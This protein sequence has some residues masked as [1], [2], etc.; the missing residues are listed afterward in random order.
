M[1][2]CRAAHPAAALLGLVLSGCIGDKS[3]DVQPPYGIQDT[4]D[5]NDSN[6]RDRDGDG[7][8][9]GDGDCNDEDPAVHPGAAD[10]AGD[11]LDTDCDGA[12]G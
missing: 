11:G 12:D 5:I 6:A 2:D 4:R 3:P 1:G 7:F 8:T 9:V 10:A